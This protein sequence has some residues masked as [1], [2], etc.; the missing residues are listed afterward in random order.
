MQDW[1]HDRAT[2]ISTHPELGQEY[3]LVLWDGE[4][5]ASTVHR[6]NIVAVR[7]GKGNRNQALALFLCEARNSGQIHG[8]ALRDIFHD[9]GVLGSLY[10]TD[11][12]LLQGKIDE[13]VL[14]PIHYCPTHAQAA[15]DGITYGRAHLAQIKKGAVQGC[16]T[17]YL[18]RYTT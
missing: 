18:L 14:E 2:F 7:K 3:S 6:K 15:F 1:K 12:T 5:E 9:L 10:D 4:S 8:S 17:R 11:R 16:P 13:G